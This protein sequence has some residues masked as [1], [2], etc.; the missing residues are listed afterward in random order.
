MVVLPEVCDITAD[1]RTGYRDILPRAAYLDGVD[2]LALHCRAIRLMGPCIA[3]LDGEI[4][5][6]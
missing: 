3:F 5:G 1:G 6:Q 2:L 4:S